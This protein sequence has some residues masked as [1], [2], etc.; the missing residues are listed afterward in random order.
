M[1]PVVRAVE[2]QRVIGDAQLVDQG[3]HLAHVL[4]VIDH[5]VVIFGLPAARLTDASRLLVSAEV[6]VGGIDP[7]KERLAGLVLALHPVGRHGEDFI[8]DGFHALLRQRTGIFDFLRPV[9]VGP[10]MQ[11]AAWAKLLP[12][13]GV[14]RV[15]AQLRLF[16]GIEVIEVAEKLVEAVRSGQVL[17]AVAE[18]VLAE[19]AG[20]ITERLQ[21]LGDGGVFGPHTQGGARQPDFAQ[22]G[23]KDALARDECRHGPPCSSARRNNP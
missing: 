8:V 1:R 15:V 17:I 11:H 12:E 16:L 13:L 18:M 6:H 3:Q 5:H 7:Y 14:F 22:T 9:G 2:E 19:L 10:G 4:V 20:G 21:K 23:A